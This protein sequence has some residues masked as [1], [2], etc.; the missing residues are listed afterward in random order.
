MP[1]H[2]Q[3]VDATILIQYIK[4]N[5][6]DPLYKKYKNWFK[7]QSI[8]KGLLGIAKKAGIKVI[9][10]A[11]LMY[12]AYRRP[13]TPTWAKRIV[14]GVLGY[15][16]APIDLIPDLSPIIGFTDD[17]SF[18]MLGLVTIAGYVNKEVKADSRLQLKKWFGDYDENDLKEVDDKI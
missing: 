11:L 14:I 9:Y 8:G 1:K 15:L 2:D 6:F 5:K 18:L 4:M 10:A 7:D 12:F 3:M 13:D 16:L 17:L